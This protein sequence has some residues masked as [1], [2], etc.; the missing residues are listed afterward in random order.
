MMPGFPEAALT[1]PRQSAPAWLN[2]L[3]TAGKVA[4]QAQPFPTRKTEAWKYTSL[5]PL[6]RGGYI[7][8]PAAAL[9]QDLDRLV[10]LY[11]VPGLEACT[12]VFVNGQY[13]Q[14]LS[15]SK[16]PDGI[17]LV[18]FADASETDIEAIRSWLGKVVDRDRHLFAALNDSW[19]SDGVFVRIDANTRVTTP[20][21]VVNLTLGQ[22]A[23]F[24][25]SA[26]LLVV[27]ESGSEASIVEHFAS[28]AQPQQSFTNS[29]TEL[30]LAP[31]ARLNHY[32]LHLEEEH[33]VHIGGVHVD[34]ARDASL[35]S[36]H[37]GLGGRLK[38]IDVVVNHQGEGA[39]CELNGVYLPR[40]DQHIDYHTCIE[41]RVPRCTTNESFRGIIADRAKA[42][43]NGRIH[44]HPDA[45]KSDAQLSNRNLLTSNTA[46]IDTKPELEIY[47]DDVKC[48]HGATVAQL[49]EMSLY[50]L[51]SRGISRP[52]A[53]VMLSFGFINEL[54]NRVKHPPLADFLRPK[55]ALLFAEQEKL[56]R[57]IVD[58]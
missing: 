55:L 13:S 36:F 4:W 5:A 54:V 52:E 45:Q 18:R 56:A 49:E 9:D 58:E 14:E 32:R 11:E 20:I 26:R 17:A 50:Y 38:R 30:V 33:A 53:E 48:A 35:D 41:H 44:I 23:G 25:I 57:H 28:D 10:A 3:H 40:H 1:L 21:H 22:D 42:V 37:M 47:A 46:Q 39:H 2:D 19:V 27:A 24:S 29:I 43:F 12:Q 34:L 16:L 8:A 31:N 6:E 15:T 7:G 51:V